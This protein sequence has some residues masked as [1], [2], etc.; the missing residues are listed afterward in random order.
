MLM[1]RIKTCL[2]SFPLLWLMLYALS[3]SAEQELF[4]NPQVFDSKQAERIILVTYADKYIN[5][6]LIGTTDQ[7]YRRRGDYGSSTWSKRVASGIEADYK[8]KILSQWPIKEIGEHCVV[9]LI[10]DDRPLA[11]VISTLSRDDRIG[12]VQA[13]NTFQVMAANTYSD[14][15]YRLQTSIHPMNLAKIH[16]QT[17][18]KNVTIAIIDTGVDTNHP[19]LVGQIQQSKDFVA[20][21]SLNSFGD[22][23]GTAIAGVIAAKPNNDQGIVGI[24]PDSSVISLKACWGIKEGSLEAVCNSFTLALAINTAIEMKIN[25]LNLSLTGP[26]DSLLARLIEKAIQQGI[27]IIASQADKIDE[28]SGFPAQQPGVIAVRSINN[29]IEQSLY[30]NSI[31][32]LSA[33]GEDILTTLPNGTYDFVSGNSLATA[34][35]SG[36]SALLVQLKRN[37]DNQ[38]LLWLLAKINE[39]TFYSVFTKDGIR[40]YQSKFT[41]SPKMN[42]P[43]KDSL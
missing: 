9:Y 12:N 11:D 28:R 33:P 37:I 22:N 42:G 13:M 29:M 2:F 34:H 38:E 35:V 6:T 39:P 8:L 18:G 27:I 26:Y 43:G 3:V 41:E 31:L 21:K 10:T 19:D 23:H 30:G 5:R 20:Q 14:P 1:N 24:A 36:F 32:A 7:S 4:V 15:Y 16:R 40:K 17:T 25:I